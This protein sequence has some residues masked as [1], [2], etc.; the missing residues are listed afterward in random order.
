MEATMTPAIRDHRTSL[1]DAV[2]NVHLEFAQMKDELRAA[3]REIAR[4]KRSLSKRAARPL[5]LPEGDLSSLRRNVAFHCHPDRSGDGELMRRL[6]V[7]FDYLECS[8][9]RQPSTR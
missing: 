4:L 7:L 6:N 1:I 8:H 5:A 2:A 3:H 9:Q